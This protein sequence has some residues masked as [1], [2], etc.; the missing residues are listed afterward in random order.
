MICKQHLIPPME[1]NE[2]THNRACIV[3]QE[4]IYCLCIYVCEHLKLF[5]NGCFDTL[6]NDVCEAYETAIAHLP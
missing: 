2:L 3:L 6:P 1:Q 4:T 5:L